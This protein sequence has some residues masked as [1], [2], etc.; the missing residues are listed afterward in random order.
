MAGSAWSMD[1]V[2]FRFLHPDL[3]FPRFRNESSCVLRVES[4]HGAV[5]LTGDV[6]EVVERMLVAA[7]PEML[8]ADVVL[9]AHHGSGKSS[10][11][12]FINA[13]GARHAIASAGHGNRFGHPH[14]AASWRWQ[15]G[16]ASVV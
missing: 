3:H 6:G 1:G 16:G 13:T 5:L 9:M 4:A 14:P 8:Q 2:R 11:R 7:Q 15:D 12:S 10:D